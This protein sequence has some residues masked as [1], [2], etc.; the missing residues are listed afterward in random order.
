MPIKHTFKKTYNWRYLLDNPLLFIFLL[1]Q[2]TLNVT[3]VIRRIGST[4]PK[5]W[6]IIILLETDWILQIKRLAATS[7]ACGEE[8][9]PVKSLYLIRLR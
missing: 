9:I 6:K 7:D 5:T 1:V 2:R 4:S 8:L 3:Y